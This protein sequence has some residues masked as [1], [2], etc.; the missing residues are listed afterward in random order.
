MNVK[1]LVASKR[2]PEPVVPVMRNADAERLLTVR[3]LYD[4]LP[5]RR[6]IIDD[7]GVPELPLVGPPDEY[8]L[9]IV[10]IVSPCLIIHHVIKTFPDALVQGIEILFGGR[11]THQTGTC[12]AATVYVDPPYMSLMVVAHKESVQQLRSGAQLLDTFF[13]SNDHEGHVWWVN[14]DGSCPTRARLVRASSSEQDF[15]ALHQRI[16]KSL[17]DVV[18]YQ[19]WTDDGDDDKRIFIGWTD[20]RQL[21]HAYI[22]Y[23][24]TSTR[25]LVIERADGEEPFSICIPHYRYD[26]F[27]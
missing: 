27:R 22:V 5:C 18:Y 20:E 15:D 11:R 2:L 24:F 16:R 21:R 7:V 4:E 6:E 25:Q 3:A 13:V 12:R 9:V 10:A 14:I 26:W 23:Y 1:I 8:A 17:D 19:A